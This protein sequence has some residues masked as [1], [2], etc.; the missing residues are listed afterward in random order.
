MAVAMLL[1]LSKIQSP[2]ERFEYV[3]PPAALNTREDEFDVVGPIRL[4]LEVQKAGGN[5]FRLVGRAKTTLE[6]DCSRC[7]ELFRIDVDASFDLSYLPQVEN[8]GEPEREIQD[9][10]LSTSFYR[11]N[12]IDLGDVLREQFYLALPMK[13]LHD[14]NCKGLCPQCGANLNRETC[15]CR[16]TWEDPRLAGLKALLDETTSGGEGEIDKK[17]SVH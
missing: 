12:T 14:E 17:K 6:V 8:A 13:P 15:E 16:P 9:E 2:R 11:G 1:D 10:D 3:W 5:K 7:L 4:D